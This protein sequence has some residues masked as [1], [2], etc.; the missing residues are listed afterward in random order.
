MKPAATTW[1]AG[2]YHLMAERLEGAAQLVTDVAGIA[3]G[4]RVLDVACGN[5]NAALLAAQ[6]GAQVIGLDFEPAL[7]E[8]ARARVERAG[9]AVTLVTGD[10]TELP[11]PDEQFTAVISVFGVM[12]APDQARAARELARVCA[13]GGRAALAA[14]LP[15]SVMPAMGAVLAPYLPPPPAGGS[16]PSRWGDPRIHSTLLANAGLT[17]DGSSVESVTLQF[18]DREA[19]VDFLIRTAGNLIAER[20]SLT[21]QG[22]WDTMRDDLGTFVDRHNTDASPTISLQLDYLLSKAARD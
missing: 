12:Y 13:R 10:A 7:L 19:A 4:D 11:F 22:R 2:E 20:E 5:G 14:W 16:P 6:L 8:E 15:G 17:A 21:R 1:G 3:A 9:A 18:E